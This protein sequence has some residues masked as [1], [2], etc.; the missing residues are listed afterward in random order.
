MS[1]QR[2]NIWKDSGSEAAND[3]E[4]VRF[5]AHERELA[6]ALAE[7]ERVKARGTPPSYY[8]LESELGQVMTSLAEA[9]A[10]VKRLSGLGSHAADLRELRATQASLTEARALLALCARTLDE[11]YPITAQ[12]VQDW[13]AANPESPRAECC[14]CGVKMLDGNVC[15]AC[16]EGLE[17]SP[18]AAESR[19]CVHNDFM[20]GMTC[21][22][23]AEPPR[24]AAERAVLEALKTVH[25]ASLEYYVA[26]FGVE[27]GWGAVSA[28]ELALRALEGNP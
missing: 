10:D 7:V 15:K 26:A 4:W 14:S 24:A 20:R 21:D 11:D 23:C 25:R 1:I 18:R 22:Y 16:V 9:Q 28:A 3:G 17:E 6:E 12:K 27:T 19:G 13:L 2:Y 5:E 8:T